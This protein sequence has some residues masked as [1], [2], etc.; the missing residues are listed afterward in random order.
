MNLTLKEKEPGFPNLYLSSISA[1]F[2]SL[3]FLSTKARGETITTYSLV[4]PSETIRYHFDRFKKG[5]L[6]EWT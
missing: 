4:A 3:P 5:K 1:L 6:V 2:E